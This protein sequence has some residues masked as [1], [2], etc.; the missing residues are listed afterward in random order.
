MGKISRIQLRGIS[1]TP[2]DRMTEDGGCAES[3]NVQLDNT[4]LAPSFMPEDVTT[5]LGLP[6][7]IEA[8]RIFIHK[9]ANYENYIV[10]QDGRIVAYTPG[11]EDEEPLLVMELAEGEKVNDITAVGNTLVV[12]TTVDTFYS[13]FA[14]GVYKFIGSE[15]PVPNIEFQ[16]ISNYYDLDTNSF[17]VFA[18]GDPTTLGGINAF[19]VDSWN[20]AIK[21]IENGISNDNISRLTQI[22]EDLWA[23]INE[24]MNTYKAKDLFCAPFFVRFAVRLYDGSYVN[25]SVPILLGA[26][27]DNFVEVSGRK[28][29]SSSNIHSEIIYRLNNLF[30]V[31]AY[32]LSWD[33]EGWEDVVKSVD[34][35]AS[36]SVY[37]PYYNSFFANLRQT[38]S[39]TAGSSTVT[40]YEITF[41]ANGLTPFDAIEQEL[42][43]KSVFSKI[44]S[45]KI[46]DTQL[47]KGWDLA[48]AKN[49]KREEDLLLADKLPDQTFAEHPSHNKLYNYNNRLL[50]TAATSSLPR[51]YPFLNAVNIALRRTGGE[52][53]DEHAWPLVLKFH[54]R[55]SASSRTVL[56]EYYDKTPYFYTYEI[57][58]SDEGGASTSNGMPFGFVAYPDPKC[59]KLEIATTTE[60]RYE[61]TMKPHPFLN[62][63][64]GYVGLSKPIVNSD[65]LIGQGRVE[66]FLYENPRK[67]MPHSLLVYKSDN[68]FALGQTFTF[69]SKVIGIALVTTAL[70][71]GQFGQFPLYVFTEDG[72]WAMETAAD[73]SF[74]S[75]KPLSRDVCVN[76]DSI[77]SI[78]NA[79]VF[80]SAQGV[81]M[82][83]G[84][85]VV[86]ISPFMNG[87]HYTIENGAKNIIENQDFFCD[88]LPALSDDTHFMAFVKEA[89]IAYD[90][91]GRRLIFIKKDEKYQ[92]IYKLDTQTW[93][94]GVF[95]TNL[96]SPINSYPECLVQAVNYGQYIVPNP[97]DV[98][99]REEWAEQMMWLVREGWPVGRTVPDIFTPT[100]F[101]KFIIGELGAVEV[102]GDA[103]S[104]LEAFTRNDVSCKLNTMSSQIYSLSTVLDAAESKTPTRGVIAT[105]P[106]DLGEPD[107]FK[108]ITDVRIRGQ[109][110]KGAVK[111]ILLGS[112]DGINF[113]T[114]STLRG[115]SWKLFRMII[116][117]DLGPT[118]RISWVDIM[119]DTK[120]TNKLR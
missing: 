16:S 73:G 9:T 85:Q 19:H 27:F 5:K 24:K 7:G 26:G 51:G 103:E 25:H 56:G 107:V 65:N 12:S 111:F 96:V 23:A 87:R 50:A 81:M 117:A 21:D 116:L 88:L 112:N 2:S 104:L 94:K 118:D 89:T 99:F 95:G 36:T 119:Y 70:S 80:V 108:T 40:E 47:E 98:D 83:Q 6:A 76:A 92:Y 71:Q 91:A 31:Y 69:Q 43:S 79:V 113:T 105:R 100:N 86:N 52:S 67:E 54:V 106:F 46:G 77:T 120:F 97:P 28:N 49:I 53:I 58:T 18:E 57:D 45:F 38:S 44:G 68:P 14:D 48:E 82:L 41:D 66:E 114:I 10:V 11:I 60:E 17:L 4:E 63:S 29:Q 75:Q 1:R 61:I 32:L 35:F 3:L 34:I 109:F 13:L 30:K 101:Y 78:D 37:F 15:I 102:I 74:V 64:Y 115:R 72:I 20:E 84:S 8:E 90:Y 22:K 110:P 39:S 42:L 59:N 93:H 55:G 62:C 33:T